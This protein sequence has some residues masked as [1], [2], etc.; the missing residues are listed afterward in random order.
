ML[1][2]LVAFV[3]LLSNG[4]VPKGIIPYLG[5]ANLFAANKKYGGFRPIANTIRRLTSKCMSYALS[6]RAASLLRPQQ[7]GVGVKGGAE[8]II[9]ATKSLLSN[10]AVPQ[11][12]KWLL[13]IDFKNAFN[14][15]DRSSMLAEAREQFPGNL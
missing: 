9:H 3:N 2:I 11:D 5:G 8:G 13:Q 10:E 6:G 7:F 12:E 15:L 14:T 4:D 1:T